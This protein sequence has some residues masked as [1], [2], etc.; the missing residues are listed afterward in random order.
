MPTAPPDP[1]HTTPHQPPPRFWE[2][3]WWLFGTSV[4]LG[5]VMLTASSLGGHPGLGLAMLGIMVAFGSV[6]LLGGRNETIRLMG[7]PDERW[8]AIDL[9]ATAI[10][11]LVLITVVIGAFVWELAHGRDG[12][13]FTQLGAIGGVA[14]LVA[15][16]VLRARS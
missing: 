9:A 10:A 3:K 16:L 12:S 4:F 5:L 8:R 2:S 14:Y 1:T 15:L 11:G 6:F 7:R 13:P